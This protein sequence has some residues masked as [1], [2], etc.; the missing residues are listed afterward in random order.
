MSECWH[1]TLVLLESRPRRR[2]VHCH[3]TLSVDELGDG[4]CPECLES[5]GERH[6]DFEDAPGDGETQS[7]YFCDDCGA[8]IG[9]ERR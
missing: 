6:S 1:T 3:L 8:R 9:G 4:P 7:G 5:R 2:C